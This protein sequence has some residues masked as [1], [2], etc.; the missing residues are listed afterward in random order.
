MGNARTAF[1]STTSAHAI[2]VDS[3]LHCN[4]D[5]VHIGLTESCSAAI[6]AACHPPT[7]DDDARFFP[8]QWGVVSTDKDGYEHCALSMD[9]WITAPELGKYFA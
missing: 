1:V 9:R 6:S 5:C 2:I 4:C 3:Y 8:V 7:G